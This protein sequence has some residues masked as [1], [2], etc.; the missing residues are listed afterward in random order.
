MNYLIELKS[1]RTEIFKNY[2][3]YVVQW[4]NIPCQLRTPFVKINN[5]CGHF[6]VQCTC[7]FTFCARKIVNKY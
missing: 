5:L 4:K 6:N 1:Y 2:S 7:L 3:Q